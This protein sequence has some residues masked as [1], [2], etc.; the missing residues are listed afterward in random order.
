MVNAG[1]GSFGIDSGIAGISVRRPQPERQLP[2]HFRKLT[3]G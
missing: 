2:A 3:L 1:T